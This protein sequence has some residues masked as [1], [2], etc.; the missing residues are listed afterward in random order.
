MVKVKGQIDTPL[1]D[2]SHI[3]E[4]Y[5][6]RKEVFLP[7]VAK[8]MPKK[9]VWFGLREVEQKP[10]VVLRRLSE[11]EW[12]SIN[13]RF[14]Q[15]KERMAKDLPLLRKLIEKNNKGQILKAEEMKVLNN[16]QNR[17][18]PIYIGMLELMIEEPKMNYDDV[19]LLVDALD[20]YDKDTLISYVN[21]LTSEKASVAQRINQERI[22]ELNQ[23]QSKLSAEMGV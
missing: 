12:R 15:T 13:E 9:K 16:A 19:R 7:S 6:Q 4:E 14:W 2:M 20:D 11:E 10:M 21:S 1:I 5:W 17:S 3:R 18:M 22:E 23:M 8:F